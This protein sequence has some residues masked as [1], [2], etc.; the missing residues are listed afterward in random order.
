MQNKSQTIELLKLLIPDGEF[1]LALTNN[2][3]NEEYYSHKLIFDKVSNKMR[4]GLDFMKG[5]DMSKGTLRGTHKQHN[6]YINFK[7]ESKNFNFNLIPGKLGFKI[8]PISTYFYI[9]IRGKSRKAID[10]NYDDLT[11]NA[12]QKIVY[13]NPSRPSFR[14]IMNYLKEKD[15]LDELLW[16]FEEKFLVDV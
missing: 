14:Y 9:D 2:M 7:K 15:L 16:V 3:T 13:I 8:G 11:Y 12:K 5:Q 4:T 10:R 6:R 1:E